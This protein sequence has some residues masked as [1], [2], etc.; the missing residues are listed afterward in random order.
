MSS[1]EFGAGDK[2]LFYTC[3]LVFGCTPVSTNLQPSW[4][5]PCDQTCKTPDSLQLCGG[6]WREGSANGDHH[7]S[8]WA[9]TTSWHRWADLGS[10]LGSGY[11]QGFRVRVTE[12]AKALCQEGTMFG[13]ACSHP[14][15]SDPVATGLQCTISLCHPMKR[16]IPRLCVFPE[17]HTTQNG[18]FPRDAAF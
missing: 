17:W 1:Q 2:C 5:G 16:Y 3:I 8:L 13:S 6:K 14:V 7:L 9:A 12:P 11:S 18:S 10:S 4:Q 15:Q